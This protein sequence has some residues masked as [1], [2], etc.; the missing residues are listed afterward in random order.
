MVEVLDVVVATDDLGVVSIE[1]SFF[2][3]V[4]VCSG[5][6]SCSLKV[7]S[8]GVNFLV[9]GGFTFFAL[10][11]VVDVIVVQFFSMLA[12]AV[13]AAIRTGLSRWRGVKQCRVVT[14]SLVAMWCL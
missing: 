6:K 1:V 3:V 8:T 7:M 2:W 12:Y 5:G 14:S 10:V 13:D 9:R 11:C 4:V